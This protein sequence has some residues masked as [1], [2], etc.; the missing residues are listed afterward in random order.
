M[1]LTPNELIL[2]AAPWVVLLMAVLTVYVS[3][4]SL[5][6][7]RAARETAQPSRQA[8]PSGDVWLQL[9]ADESAVVRKLLEKDLLEKTGDERP[10]VISGRLAASRR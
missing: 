4:P 3:K 2:I 10:S 8:E 9:T 5:M 7:R 1:R 6:R